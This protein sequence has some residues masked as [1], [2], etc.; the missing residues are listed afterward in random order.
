VTTSPRDL[1]P[2]RLFPPDPGVRRLDEDEAYE[3]IHDLVDTNPR[4]AFQR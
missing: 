2:D 3:V 1:H 4:R